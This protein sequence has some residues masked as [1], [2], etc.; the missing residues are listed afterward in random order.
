LFIIKQTI[1][2]K[3]QHKTHTHIDTHIH[4]Y[5]LTHTHIYIYTHT[6]IHNTV[7]SASCFGRRPL[8]MSLGVL[9][10]GAIIVIMIRN[11]SC[12]VKT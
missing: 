3:T 11:G 9:G 4:I 10:Q 8:C 2:S 5:T 1:S 12:P 6:Y 7:A